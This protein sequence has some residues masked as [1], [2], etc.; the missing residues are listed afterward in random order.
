MEAQNHDTVDN[1]KR[2]KK[3]LTIEERLAR[4]EE[5]VFGDAE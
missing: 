5:T 1:L 4:L 3:T 2:E